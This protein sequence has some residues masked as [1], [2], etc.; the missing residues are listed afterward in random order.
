MGCKEFR[1]G[2]GRPEVVGCT[3]EAVFYDLGGLQGRDDYL[4]VCIPDP[5]S[6]PLGDGGLWPLLQDVPPSQASALTQLPCVSKNAVSSTTESQD[7]SALVG[8]PSLRCITCRSLRKL[9]KLGSAP[10]A[11]LY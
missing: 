2:P 5:L 9:H 6:D 10:F 7:E 4:E 1:N 8:R 3:M 11:M